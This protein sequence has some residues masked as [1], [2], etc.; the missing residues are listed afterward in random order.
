MLQKMKQW[1]DSRGHDKQ[2][3]LH[4]LS[5]ANVKSGNNKRI[6]DQS[7]STGHV[8][9]AMLPQGGLQEVLKQ[10]NV[11]VVSKASDEV[12]QSTDT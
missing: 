11:H 4:R 2:E 1:I 8:H 9:N 3:I 6:G 12:F 10:H 7:Q 5:S